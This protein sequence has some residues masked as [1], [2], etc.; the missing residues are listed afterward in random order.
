MNKEY[1]EK[2]YRRM[3]EDEDFADIAVYI[4]MPDL[5][6]LETISNPKGNQEKKLEYYLKAYNDNMQ[7]NTFN[8]IYI[9]S[10]TGWNKSFG[11]WIH[12]FEIDDM[13]KDDEEELE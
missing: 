13:N 3:M 7:L 9:H 12:P 2:C 5:P 8:Q 11:Y 10:L 4:C 1:F 6:S